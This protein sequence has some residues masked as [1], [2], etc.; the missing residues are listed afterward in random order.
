MDR[1]VLK[2]GWILCWESPSLNEKRSE[3]YVENPKVF[4]W[5]DQSLLMVE[6]LPDGGWQLIEHSS[7]DPRTV[8]KGGDKGGVG[9]AERH[10]MNGMI[11]G[12]VGGHLKQ[13]LLKNGIVWV[14]W[15]H[16]KKIAL[17]NTKRVTGWDDLRKG[18]GRKV[19]FFFYCLS[20]HWAQELSN[21]VTVHDFLVAPITTRGCSGK[22]CCSPFK[23]TVI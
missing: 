11:F 17:M 5:N 9:R 18:D 15:Y 7:L 21:T 8:L 1:S 3:L 13:R 4:I 19:F 12:R 16:G 14:A 2:S 20:I 10:W 6:H 23:C 22:G